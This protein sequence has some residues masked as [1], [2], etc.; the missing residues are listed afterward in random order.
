MERT[1]LIV[2]TTVAADGGV[3]YAALTREE[4]LTKWFA[5]RAQVRIASGR[6][7]FGGRYTPHWVAGPYLVINA[8]RNRRIVL[9]SCLL[10]DLVITVDLTAGPDGRTALSIM[11]WRPPPVGPDDASAMDFWCLS[12]GNLAN[13]VEGR[14]VV[15]HDFAA[16]A[17]DLAH[18]ETTI[19]ASPRT[20]F[21]AL[22]RP[23][24]LEQWI[25]ATAHVQPRVGGAY[26][27]GWG[28]DDG[29]MKIIDIVPGRLLA[30]DWRDAGHPDSVVRWTLAS[31][32]GGTLVRVDHDL[33]GRSAERHQIGWENFLIDLQR[34]LET[35][36][37]WHRTVWQQ[38][39][40][41]PSR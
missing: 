17:H 15:R 24:R 6:F 16:P 8:E 22:V 3:V 21:A 27:F 7:S 37:D 29:P 34:M 35:G 14:D 4:A 18:A 12:A 23:V 5:E 1:R 31:A 28:Q 32:P 2:R 36:G 40:P 38:E 41:G 11:Q 26:T 30:H 33:S 25:A 13:F 19:R 10:R 39:E 20:V 9:G